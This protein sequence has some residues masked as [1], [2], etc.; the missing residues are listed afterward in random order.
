M[1]LF[2]P[3]RAAERRTDRRSAAHRSLRLALAALSGCTAVLGLDDYRVAQD[4]PLAVPAAMGCRT[5]RDCASAGVNAQGFPLDFCR[6]A[7][8]RCVALRS[9]Q[10]GAV[11]GPAEDDSAILIGSLFTTSGPQAAV[12]LARQQAAQLAIAELNAGGGLPSLGM[13]AQR[14]LVLVSC[15]ANGGAVAAAEHLVHELGSAAIVGPDASQDFIDV[16]LQVTI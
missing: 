13:R 16:A 15:D 2:K 12:N 5:H 1:S 14:P 6:P 9:A 10:C 11:S 7:T 4:S 3:A 8:Q